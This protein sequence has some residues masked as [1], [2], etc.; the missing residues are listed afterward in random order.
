MA[1][2]LSDF[3]VTKNHSR[4]YQ[5]SDNPYSEAHFKTLKY[6]P[7]FPEKFE[8]IES[9]RAYCQRFFKWYNQEHYHSGI[10]YYTPESVHYK[11]CDEIYIN[12][13]EVLF[14]AYISNPDRFRNK[15]PNT[16]KPPVDAWIN[17]PKK[18]KIE[19]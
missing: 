14:E 18:E 13:N 3:S 12:R 11:Y 8:T 19:S 15:I 17:K 16:A 9:A 1:F 5:S 10:G 4:P 7:L 6:Q 2:L